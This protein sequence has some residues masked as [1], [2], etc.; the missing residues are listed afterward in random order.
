MKLKQMLLLL[1]LCVICGTATAQKQASFRVK[2]LVLDSLTLQGE[3]YATVRLAKKAQPGKALKMVLTNDEGKFLVQGTGQGEFM[4]SVTSVGRNDIVRSFTVQEDGQ[5]VDLGT[6]YFTS[7]DNVL[8][9]VEVVAQKPLV[10]ADIDKITYNVADDPDSETN[11]LME[12]LRKVPM[13]TVDG[14][15]NI[16]VNGS[17]SFKVYVNGKPN[18]MM[19]NNPK[20]VLKSMPANTIKNIEVI[21]NPGPKYDA[22][23]VGGILNIITEGGGFEGYTV[24]VNGNGSNR[25]AG[26]GVFGTIQS[27]KLTVSARYNYDYGTSPR[28]YSGGN[29]RATEPSSTTANLDYEGSGKGDNQFQ[30][31]SLEASYEIDT[32]NLVSA[33]FGLWGGGYDNHGSTGYVGTSSLASAPGELYRYSLLN[34]GSSSWYSID[35]SID[36]QHIFP[37]VKNRMLTVSYKINTNPDASESYTEYD[38]DPNYSADWADYLKRLEDLYMDNSQNTVEHTAQVDFTTPIGKWHTLETGVKYIRRNNSSDNDRYER[39]SGMDDYVFDEEYST[40]YRHQNDILAA[41][42]GYALR[43]KKLSARAGLRYEH[44][45][46][47]VKYLLGRGDDFRK[48]FNDAVPSM[49]VGWKLSDFSNVRVGYNMRIYR[50]GIWYLNPYLDDSN[51]SAVSQGNPDLDSEK[52]HSVDLSYSSFSQKFNINLSA[53]YS[54]TNNS[55]QSVTNLVSEDD[56]PGLNPDNLTGKDVLYTTYRNIGKSRN[57]NLNAYINWNASPNTRIYLNMSGGYVHMKGAGELENHG[58]NFFGFGGA[59]QTFKHDWRL[60]LNAYGQTPYIMLQGKGSNFV[61]YSISLNK[62]F[63]KKRLTLS[64]YASNFFQKYQKYSSHTEGTGFRQENWNR[65][66]Q[67]RVGLSIS[68][69]FGELKASVKKAARTISN[70]DVKSGGGGSSSS[71]GMGGE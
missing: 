11:S 35:G 21:T 71:G 45:I 24:T 25:G 23:G 39:T 54:F 64:A 40:H 69:R 22:E 59:Q 49:S 61:G 47:N 58:W 33:S 42:L 16:Q 13:V 9:E 2:G 8:Q 68:Y 37:H 17:S 43:W 12:M 53:R 27:G 3:S 55:I 15:D 29:R 51:P 41:Y 48:H 19:S 57:A 70:D 18:N 50:P 36:Y 26:G 28:S 30:S 60:S 4:V 6:L 63:L 44:T 52:N 5:E 32:L 38:I 62:S 10:K 14:E 66:P 46:Q 56:I 31:G 34:R 7:A 1:C 67:A 20:E 65:Y